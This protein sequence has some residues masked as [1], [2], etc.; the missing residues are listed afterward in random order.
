M[1]SFCKVWSCCLNPFR[2]Y[3]PFCRRPLPLSHPH[4][5]VS[6]SAV[7]WLGINLSAKILCIS[8]NPLCDKTLLWPRPLSIQL[9]WT[10][11]HTF[12]HLTSMP[13]FLLIVRWGHFCVIVHICD[14]ASSCF[15]L[16]SQFTVSCGVWDL[17]GTCCE[18]SW[19]PLSC[20]DESITA[21]MH[22]DTNNY[23]YGHIHCC[24]YHYASAHSGVPR[25]LASVYLF[26]VRSRTPVIARLQHLWVRVHSGKSH[27]LK[28]G[29]TPQPPHPG[30]H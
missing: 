12:T 11:T 7:C 23:V 9:A 30:K 10:Q 14:H 13:D 22:S 29:C 17:F 16:F 8:L 27:P 18:Y 19:K 3:T 1:V 25:Y 6:L 28:P 21:P 4:L 26:T 5:A 20:H 2:S 24:L 15:Y